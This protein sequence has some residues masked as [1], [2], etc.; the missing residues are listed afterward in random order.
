MGV[1]TR[2]NLTQNFDFSAQ[3]NWQIFMSDAVDGLQANVIEN[4]S[5]E[6]MTSIQ[7]GVVYHLNFFKSM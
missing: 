3:I 6:T 7:L 5:S 4:K 1:G 2:L